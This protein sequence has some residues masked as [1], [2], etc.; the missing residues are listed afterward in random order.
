MRTVSLQD[1][2][3]QKRPATKNRTPFV[4]TG[5]AVGR[6][7]HET[8]AAFPPPHISKLSPLFIRFDSTAK[9]IG[10]IVPPSSKPSGIFPPKTRKSSTLH[11][12]NNALEANL[13]K[14]LNL[15]KH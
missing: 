6:Q 4:R 10:D 1:V 8:H 5:T 7:F 15:G 14:A 11:Q 2:G 13:M 12:H 3:L 9:S